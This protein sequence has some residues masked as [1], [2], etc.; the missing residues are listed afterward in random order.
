M[1]RTSCS[2]GRIKVFLNDRRTYHDRLEVAEQGGGKEAKVKF[3]VMISPWN[4]MQAC[5]SHS[6]KEE[7][8]S[9]GGS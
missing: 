2:L 1:R 4:P 6:M 9:G 7:Q 8:G 3:V 5:Y